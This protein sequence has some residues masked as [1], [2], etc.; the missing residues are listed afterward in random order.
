MKRGRRVKNFKQD[1]WESCCQEIAERG[2]M[3]KFS[4][5]E[6]L[7][8]QLLSTYP[9]T[10]VEASPHDKIWGIGLSQDDPN[11]WNKLTWRGKNLLGEILTTVRDRLRSGIENAG[12][13]GNSSDSDL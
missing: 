9:K 1:I 6:D 10:L 12:P 8:Q 2:I 3:E 5:N 11:A 13:Y 4:Q 7:K